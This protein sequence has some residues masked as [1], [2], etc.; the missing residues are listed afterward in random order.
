M[1][2]P[3][4]ALDDVQNVLEPRDRLKVFLQTTGANPMATVLQSTPDALHWPPLERRL[5]AAL[6][7]WPSIN[8]ASLDARILRDARVQ[9]EIMHSYA[10]RLPPGA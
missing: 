10:L 2:L 4:D 3:H 8:P 1:L 5:L 9:N 7:M 6:T